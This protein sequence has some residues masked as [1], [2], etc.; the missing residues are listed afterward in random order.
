M[1]IP[2]IS[3]LPTAP[4]RT[5]PPATFVTRADSFL[6]AL[7]V[8]QGELNTSIGAMNTD[9]TQ[10]NADAISAA[11]SATAAANAS[12]ASAWVS[13]TTYA[14]GDVVYSPIDYQ[15]YRRIIAGAGT[16]DPSTDA[17]NW[18]KISAE[19]L[20]SQTGNA[21]SYLTTNGTDPSWVQLSTSPTLE[22]VASGS[23]AN[24]DMVVVNSDGTVSAVFDNTV[25]QSVSSPATFDSTTTLFISSAFDSNSNKVVVAY[26]DDGLGAGSAGTAVVGTVS[27]GTISFGTPVVFQSGYTNEIAC[28]FD[29]NSNKI[30]ISYR[31]SSNGKAIVG[32]V[33]G[34]SISFGSAVTFLA[35]SNND[36]YITFDSNENKVVLF[37][38]D[39]TNSS[40]LT[41]KVGTVS[42]T[43]ISFGSSVVVDGNPENVG[44]TFD[45]T[46]NKVIVTFKD[47]GN[48]SYGTAR[49]GTVSGTS[50]SFGSATVFNSNTTAFTACAYNSEANKTLVVYQNTNSGQGGT[51]R[52]GTVSGTSISFGT[53]TEFDGGGADQI[54]CGYDSYAKK[55]AIAWRDS[56]NRGKIVSS[57]ISGTSV[58]YDS[59]V[60]FETGN[61]MYTSIVFDNSQNKIVTS[62]RDVGDSSFGK[63]IVFTTGFIERNLTSENFIGISDDTY[64]DGATAKIQIIGSVDD[65]QSGL[66]A[67]EKY[68]VQNDNTLELTPDSPNV[69]AGTA[70]SA[71]KIIVKG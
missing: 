38:E 47:A 4:A 16:T 56:A 34:T 3:T 36:N 29:S 61:T 68:Y 10:V 71:T 18:T 11:A 69:F 60:T 64:S 40:Q 50:I 46:A 1:T 57:N 35:G 51:G 2:T 52:V 39:S 37:Y 20:P 26:Q 44:A 33:S 31:N 6:A 42:G 8:M 25:T 54:S 5:D 49:V 27:G 15:S 41:A 65:A 12:N 43:S 48:S 59:N 9:I 7:V 45:T 32:T 17:T 28:T 24:G 19:P 14:L 55:V 66:T 63:S 21:G 30:V 13:G 67:G 62:Y 53:A 58:S 70:V 23:L 22:A